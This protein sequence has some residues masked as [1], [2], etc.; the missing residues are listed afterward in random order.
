MMAV[1]GEPSADGL[2]MEDLEVEVG[3][4]ASPLPTGIVARMTLD[5]DVVCKAE[6]EAT[7]TEV[8]PLTPDPTTPAAWQAALDVT[9]GDGT[10]W[11]ADVEVERAASH[12]RYFMALGALLGWEQLV[13]R[14][15]ELARALHRAPGDRVA[16]HAKPAALRLDK[17]ARSRRLGVRLRGIAPVNTER[18]ADL[19]LAGPNVRASGVP[20]DARAAH[21]AYAA[22]GFTPVVE[23]HGDALARTRVRAREIGV[24]LDVLASYAA[25]RPAVPVP[26]PVLVEGPR[27]PLEIRPDEHGDRAE[28]SARGQDAARRAAAQSTHRLE[29]PNALLAIVSFDLAGWR[30]P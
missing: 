15:R 4:I 12:A 25:A 7:L 17:L 14:A 18:A 16:E 21:P 19:G 26:T 1:T 27:G 28:L 8:D 10:S 24:S 23:E 9:G 20:D 29:W 6:I 30:L 5:G 11:I 13:D 2:V 22:L 3:P